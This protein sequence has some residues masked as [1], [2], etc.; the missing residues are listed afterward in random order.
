MTIPDAAIPLSLGQSEDA[1]FFPGL[2]DEVEIFRRALSPE[3]VQA[4]FE[5]G[6]VGKCKD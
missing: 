6:G 5:A 1:Y 4:I 3:E 2:L